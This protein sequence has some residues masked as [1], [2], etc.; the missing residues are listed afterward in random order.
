MIYLLMLFAVCLLLFGLHREKKKT[1]I[2]Y[3]VIEMHRN[4]FI[5]MMEYHIRVKNP[6][7]SE[8]YEIY[9]TED[10]FKLLPKCDG[11]WH[12]IPG[13]DKENYLR[14]LKITGQWKG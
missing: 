10:S 3:M 14:A 8:E 4:G 1:C 12:C 5:G 6:I 11:G 9:A 7:T 2:Q 13:D